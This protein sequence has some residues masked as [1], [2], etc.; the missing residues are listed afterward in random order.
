MILEDAQ[1]VNYL[2]S[3]EAV[4][5]RFY[6]IYEYKGEATEFTEISKE[7]ADQAETAYQYLDYCAWRCCGMTTTMNSF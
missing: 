5:R 1:L 6:L 3:Y 4:T 7:L 2:A